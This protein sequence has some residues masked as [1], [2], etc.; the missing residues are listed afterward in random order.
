MPY[1]ISALI[2]KGSY[3][4]VFK[5]TDADDI[6]KVYA[7][8]QIDVTNANHYECINVIN[9]MRVLASH[10]CP[11][12]VAFKEVYFKDTHVYIVT[13]FALNGDLAG[14]IATHKKKGTTLV[15]SDVWHY[16]LQL[17]VALS[18]LHSINVIHRDVK[19]ANVLVDASNNVRLADLG[20]VKILRGE[21]TQT[22]VGTP[23]YMAPEIF[24]RERYN[25]KCDTWS[26]GCIMFE[27]VTLQPPFPGN[28]FYELRDN[29]IRG[30][31]RS[32]PR[33]S[34]CDPLQ[35]AVRTLLQHLP[36]SRPT[37]QEFLKLAYVSEH[38][39]QR[40]LET[41]PNGKGVKSLFHAPCTVPKRIEDWPKVA[42]LFCQLNTTIQMND[43]T[44]EQMRVVSEL[45]SKL[46][47]PRKKPPRPQ[48]FAKIQWKKDL[49]ALDSQIAAA[50]QHLA[51]L[52]KR[53]ESLLAK[54]PP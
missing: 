37:V 51:T 9:E 34:A 50:K 19:P 3:G 27:L 5:A 44:K 18:Y 35:L 30:Y 6:N 52:Q 25:F 47:V 22:Q 1:K 31:V 26:V 54:A 24:K 39:R 17:C 7:I 45:R 2:G 49:D 8:K 23:Y 38:M 53:R 32:L 42:Q 12:L 15:D 13:E 20:V 41:I 14:L 16:S 4:A 28:N 40:G 11:F 29:V 43:S 48:S 46:A 21:S 33:R 10:S 36:R